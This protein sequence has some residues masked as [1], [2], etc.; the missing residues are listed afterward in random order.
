MSYTNPC[1]DGLDSL[2][3]KRIVFLCDRIAAIKG[4]A[5]EQ[6]LSLK[7]FFVP[8]EDS[9]FTSFILPASTSSFEVSY[10]NLQ[11][12]S[13]LFLLTSYDSSLSD[14]EKVISWSFDQSDWHSVGSILS[15]SGTDALPID[16]I[17]L[18]NEL[19]TDVT[20]NIIV[21]A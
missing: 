11:S 17:Y 18:R 4:G 20:I 14:S 6:Q 19:D 3:Q 13:I 16:T 10:G 8:V 12:P 21:G 9:L 7:S 5:T 15:L 1:Y 2:S